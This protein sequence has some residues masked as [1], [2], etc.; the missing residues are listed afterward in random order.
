MKPAHPADPFAGDLESFLRHLDEVRGASAATQRAYRTDLRAFLT[1]LGETKPRRLELRRY[2]VELEE[3]GL[4][5]TSVQ[6]KLASLRAFTRFLQE[7]GHQSSD[8][9]RL[10]RGPKI[11]KRVPRF[12]STHEVEVLMGQEFG[13]GFPGQRDRAVL[14]VL[15]STGAR[16]A[17]AARLK[18]GDLDLTVDF[19]KPISGADAEDQILELAR[20][21]EKLAAVVLARRT[22]GFSLT[23]AK[24]FVEDLIGPGAEVEGSP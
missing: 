5:A 18:L 23:E 12:L 11:P 14:E 6:R 22:F 20:R 4:K 8:S 10:I 15:Y 19:T 3:Q 13:S 21:G 24:G 1:W 2:L 9:A 17:E 7:K 16:V